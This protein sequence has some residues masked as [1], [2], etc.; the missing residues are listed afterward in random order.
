MVFHLLY[1]VLV[2]TFVECWIHFRTY[3]ATALLDEHASLYYFTWLI[4]CHKEIELSGPT[5]LGEPQ[6]LDS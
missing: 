4:A 3:S 1:A 2:Q 5:H 6:P